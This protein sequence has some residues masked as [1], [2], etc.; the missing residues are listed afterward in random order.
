MPK[1]ACGAKTRTGGVCQQPAMTNGRCRLHGGKTPRGFNSPNLKHGRY[2][3]D[4]PTRLA[5][6]YQDAADDP[7]LLSVRQDIEL[8]D[9]MIRASFS[10]LEAGENPKAWEEARKLVSRANAGYMNENYGQLADALLE[11]RLLIESRQNYYA[12]EGALRDKLEQRRRMVETEQKINLQ[13][14]RAIGVDQLML[15]MG[16]VLN[17]IMEVV[18]DR[19]QRHQIAS[20]IERIIRL[21]ESP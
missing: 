17:V 13:A 15:L 6:A 20:G 1:T 5:A 16:A 11:L 18:K 2:S 14:E 7:E 10:D 8:I 9:A 21:P 3:K 12:A 19:D 4:L